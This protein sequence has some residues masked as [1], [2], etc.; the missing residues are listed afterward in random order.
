MQSYLKKTHKCL[1]GRY[2]KKKKETFI[3]GKKIS[4]LI[5]K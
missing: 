5:V 2:A 1:R 4:E 3:D